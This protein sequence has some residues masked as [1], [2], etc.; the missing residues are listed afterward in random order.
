MRTNQNRV[1]LLE[2][3]LI[4]EKFGKLRNEKSRAINYK[5]KF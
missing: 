1:S 5:K 2:I 3:K 4:N